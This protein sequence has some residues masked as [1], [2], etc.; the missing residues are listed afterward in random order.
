MKK[1]LKLT[2]ASST[3]FVMAASILILGIAITSISNPSIPAVSA[4]TMMPGNQTSGAIL[5]NK[6]TFSS[7]LS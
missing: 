7:L 4:M 6:I 1:G 5:I 2:I 3:G